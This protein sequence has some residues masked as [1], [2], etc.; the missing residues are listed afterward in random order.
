[1]FDHTF[2][3]EAIL[4]FVIVSDTHYMLDPGQRAVEFASRRLQS[5]RAERAL[6]LVGAMNP[7]FVVHLGDL[8]QE[9]PETERYR[10]AMAEACDQLQRCGVR[11]YHVAGNQDIGDKP[12]PTMPTRWVTA[13]SLAAFHDRFGRSWYSWDKHRVHFIVLNSQLL[14]TT[15]P[16]AEAQRQWLEADLEAH[17][18]RRIFLFLHLG[19]FLKDEHEPALGHYDNIAEPARGWLIRLIRQHQIEMVFSGHSHFAFFNRLDQTRYYNLVSTSFTRPGFSQL[20]SSGPPPDQGRDDAQ[21]LGFYLVRVQAQGTSVHFIRTYGRTDRV[22]EATGSFLIN[23]VAR[24]LPH[25][26]LGLTLHHPLTQTTEVPWVWPSAIRQPVRNDY[27]FLACT[28]LGVRHLR[29]PASDLTDPLQRQRLNYLKEEGVRLEAVWLW[30]EPFDLVEAIKPYR[31]LLDGIEVQLLGALQPDEACCR[32]LRQCAAEF[33]LPV[34]LCPV[35]PNERVPGKQHLRTRL[36]YYPTE[37]EDLDHYLAE[38]KTPMERVRCLVAPQASPWET[39]N[40]AIE[41][42]ALS[43]IKVL[44]WLVDFGVTDEQAQVTRAAEVMFGLA[45]FPEARLFLGPLVDLDRT[46][47]VSYGLLDRLHNPRPVFNVIR[48]LNTILFANQEARQPLPGPSREDV[49]IIGL[50]GASATLWLLLPLM[51]YGEEVHLNLQSL[52][53]IDD[54]AAG[55]KCIYLEQGLSRSL[56]IEE[57]GTNHFVIDEAALLHS[58]ARV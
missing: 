19:L 18:D 43:H 48:Y 36:G 22:D 4:E 11:S 23:R 15:L 2:L 32:Q 8:V 30:A 51:P 29:F 20:F 31:A 58:Q 41:P 25:S 40:A 27:P 46:M 24:D 16:E 21:K 52:A 6:G 10:Q 13:Q 38:R 45:R 57:I 39:I 26:P 28:E 49:R 9:Y 42:A 7:D 12:D 54:K 33:N 17:D 53:S 5:A 14:N 37:L 56:T 35:I 55:I 47:D 34:A 44:D 1:M 3:P 50:E